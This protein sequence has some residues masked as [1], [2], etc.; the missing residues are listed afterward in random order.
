[1]LL[2]KVDKP[3]NSYNR[4]KFKQKDYNFLNVKLNRRKLVLIRKHNR[5]LT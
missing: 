2:S 5:I 4:S 3:M 1:M